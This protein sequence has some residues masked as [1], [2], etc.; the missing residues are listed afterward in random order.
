MSDEPQ[1]PEQQE[2]SVLDY[3][4]SLFRFGGERIRLPDSSQQLAVSDERSAVI[5]QPEELQSTVE[6]ETFQ[7]SNLQPVTQFPWRSLLALLFALIGQSTFEP[8]PTTSPLGYAF[9][10]AAFALLGWSIQRGEWTLAP[11]KPTS[12]AVDPLTYRR[13]ALLL[14]IPLAFWAFLLFKDNLF[15][16]ANVTIWYFAVVLFLFAFWIR[17]GN[18]RASFRDFFKFNSWT[19]LLIAATALVFFFRFYQTA[20]VPPEPFSDHAEKILDVYDVSVGQTHIFFPRNTGREAIQ[21][22]WT[23]LIAKVFGTGLSYLSL[24]LGTAILGFLTLPFVY[25]LGREIGG[26]RVGLI[27]FI[28]IGIGYWPNVISRVGLRFPLYPLFVAPTL[29][30]L[31]RGLRTRN[32]N[33][34]LLSG[35]FLGLGLHGYSPMRIVPF[36]VIAAFVL[37]WLHSQS[38]GVRKDL[39]LW[40]VMLGLTAL[41][42]FLPLLRYWIDHPTEFGFRAMSRLSGIENPITAPLLNIFSSNVWKALKMFNFDDGEI[43]VNSVPHRPALDV[44]SAALFA[45]GVVLLLVR[46]IRNRHWL[47]LFLLVSI[48]LLQLPSTLSLAFPGENPALNRAGAAY[49]PAFVIGALALDGLLTSFGRGRMRSVLL[50]G[51]AGL[52]LFVSARQNYDLVFDE[53]YTSFRQG[54]WNTSDMGRVILEF[55]QN[56]GRTDTVWVVPFPYWVDTRLPAVWA[57]IPNRDMAVWRDNLATTLELTGPKLFMVKANLEDPNGNDTET[58]DALKSL[59]PNGQLRL[60]DSDVPG[61]D[62][63]IYFV[64][65]N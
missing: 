3:V 30:F 40:L 24:K 10:I 16:A 11:L 22:Y 55:E 29:L 59:Y 20:S 37:Y 51:L 39:P 57:G 63:W 28:M 15:T 5:S 62:F 60:F 41:V 56:Y 19:L 44:I 48:P 17:G 25:L 18:G 33:D 46:Y 32:R 31:I 13:L 7:P 9:Y 8:P 61:H 49:I 6:S 1:R 21:M 12:P 2:P 23:L 4:K 65:E 45:L 35:L 34:F 36:V 14:S 43:W 64:P 38:K 50:W 47:D 53:Y 54:S 26:K 58:L 52:L 42:V 27:A